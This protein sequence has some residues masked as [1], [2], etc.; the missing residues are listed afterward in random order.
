MDS[1][2]LQLAVKYATKS[3]KLTLAQ[4][5]IDELIEQNKEEKNEQEQEKRKEKL[6]YSSDSLSNTSIKSSTIPISTIFEPTKQTRTKVE[7]K[8]VPFNNPFRK[9]KL[10]NPS[11]ESTSN[12]E[13]SKWKPSI[14]KSRLSSSN[15]TTVQVHFFN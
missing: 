7:N 1:I 11:D 3:G 6:I 4:K 5:I 8:N 12:D 14:N 15:K 10:L 2:A 13:L 9:K